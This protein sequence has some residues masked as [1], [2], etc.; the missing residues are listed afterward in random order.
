MKNY[1]FYK[2]SKIPAV[3][4]FTAFVF[5]SAWSYSQNAV[6]VTI[7]ASANPVCQGTSVTFTAIPTNGGINPIYQ[8]QVNGVNKG[9]NDSIYTYIPANNDSIICILTSSDTNVT[10]NPAISNMVIMTVYVPA[11]GNYFFQNLFRCVND[12]IA[13]TISVISG[14]GPISYQWIKDGY[15]IPGAT[16]SIY[17]NSSITLA[18]CGVYSCKVSNFC[19]STTGKL[20]KLFVSECSPDRHNIFGYVKYDNKD[21]TA[22]TRT[23]VYLWNSGDIIID[24]MMTDDNGFYIFCLLINGTYKISCKTTKRWGGVNPLDA[25]L[26]GNNFIGKYTIPDA[27]KK[28]AADVNN[29]KKINPIDALMINRRYIGIIDK[30]YVSDW[31]FS[32][33]TVNITGYD[34]FKN[35]SAICAGDVN[36]SYTQPLK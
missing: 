7:T 17:I 19:N 1:T 13:F 25:L 8:W 31:L 33:P 10:G 14:T 9:T 12:S 5:I 27:M 21:S 28:L 32:N 15:D 4:L 23:T 29:D 36:G 22:M 16:N 35:I 34:V 24:S 11:Y 2:L 20:V 3:F 18:D 26:V 30:F 6:S